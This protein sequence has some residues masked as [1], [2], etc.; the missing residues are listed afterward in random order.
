MMFGTEYIPFLGAGIF[1]FIGCTIVCVLVVRMYFKSRNTSTLLFL[2]FILCVEVWIIGSCTYPLLSETLAGYLSLITVTTAYIGFFFLFLFL[3]LIN[4]DKVSVSRAVF[5]GGLIILLVYMMITTL[6][7]GQFLDY[8]PNF[9]YYPQVTDDVLGM[10][11]QGM[12]ILGVGI[13]FILTA[14]RVRKLAETPAE[15]L[16]ARY[17]ILGALICMVGALISPLLAM[18]IDFRGFLILFESI[19]FMITGWGFVKNPDVVV[20]L[21]FKAQHL[22]VINRAGI[23][24]F[25]VTFDEKSDIDDLLVSG[26]LSGVSTLMKE[27][28]GVKSQLK[29][30][31]FGD[32]H[33]LLDLRKDIGV[34]L[35]SDTSSGMLRN[36]IKLFTDYFESKFAQYLDSPNIDNFNPAIDGVKKYMNFLPGTWK[37]HEI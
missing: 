1:A 13:E 34:F 8:I 35:I 22:L 16:Q 37:T 17:F 25:S 23:C 26:M 33:I 19:G 10:L 24:L 9:G 11:L 32:R 6:L 21:P 31:I 7:T 15:K 18:I 3:E 5:F 12:L 30:I 14:I 2:G 28:F 36:A 4:Y 27:A 29:E 20:M